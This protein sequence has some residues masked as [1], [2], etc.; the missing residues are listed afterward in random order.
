MTGFAF[1]PDTVRGRIRAYLQR[2]AAALG[3]DVLEIGSRLPSPACVWAINRDLAPGANWLGADF[4]PGDNVDVVADA[5]NLPEAWAG[6]FSSVVCSEVLEHVV[7]PWR[8]LSEARRV[9]RPGGTLLVTT[10]TTFPVHAYPNDYW[11]FTAEGL[12]V[13]MQS[14]GLRD[15]VTEQDGFFEMDVQ[16]R[17]EAARVRVRVPLHVFGR[18]VA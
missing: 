14:A 3:T 11:R 4:M 17:P 8:V 6:R 18:G 2:H 12:R 1:V 5:H 10:L 15:V 13:L 16:D 7:N 9:L